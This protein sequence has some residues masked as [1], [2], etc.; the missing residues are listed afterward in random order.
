MQ[1]AETRLQ[2][3]AASGSPSS[4]GVRSTVL[5]LRVPRPRL[6]LLDALRLVASLSV[7][8]WHRNYE[9]L[10]GVHFGVPLFL[11]ILFGFASSSEKR[12]S[13]GTFARR[14]TAFLLRPW[15][16]WSLVC[17]LVLALR[18]LYWGQS[19]LDRWGLNT[20]LMGGHIYYWFLPFAAATIVAAKVLQRVLRPMRAEIAVLVATAIGVVATNAASLYILEMRPRFPVGPWMQSLPAL[21]FG[22]A[23]GQSLRISCFRRRGMI[24]LAM[25]GLAAAAWPLSPFAAAD[26]PRRYAIAIAL[27]CLGFGVRVRMPGIVRWLATTTFGIYLVHPLVVIAAND[28]VSLDSLPPLADALIVW[29]T[30]CLLVFALGLIFKS[31]PECANAVTDQQREA[32]RHAFASL[33][34]NAAQAVLALQGRR[35]GAATT[36]GSSTGVR[37]RTLTLLALGRDRGRRSA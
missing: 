16:R 32:V 28:L 25:A 23:L 8:F 30:S 35:I 34:E 12:E 18:D 37:T 21:F 19:P 26:M 5:S 7:I 24:L 20:L 3:A 36:G 2:T 27:A 29:G 4:P 17:L 10:F 11:L 13:L 1:L 9:A 6:E 22:V 14:R 33:R 31:W 15:V